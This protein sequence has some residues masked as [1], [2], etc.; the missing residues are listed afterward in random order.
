MGNEVVNE[1]DGGA[2]N[3]SQHLFSELEGRANVTVSL[4]SLFKHWVL[5][6]K[7]PFHQIIKFRLIGSSMILV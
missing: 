1:G 4:E 3:Q 2:D 7:G 6:A 5:E